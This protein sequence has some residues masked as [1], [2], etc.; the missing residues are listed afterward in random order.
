MKQKKRCLG[1]RLV[2]FSQWT[3]KP[4]ATFCSIGKV[5]KICV[6][7][8]TLTVVA[9]QAKCESLIDTA[10]VSSHIDIDEVIVA[11]DRTPVTFTQM[12]LQPTVI[13]T[14]Q[15]D[16]APQQSL[17]DFLEYIPSL[18]IRQRGTNDVQADLSIRGGSTDQNAIIINKI[19]FSDPQTG[20]N[21]FALPI[22]LGNTQKIEIVSGAQSRILGTNAL[23]GA[24]CF[25]TPTDTVNSA[26][27]RLT[28]GDYGLYKISV[29]T[30]LTFNRLSNFAAVA[31]SHSD[32]YT[33]N[34]DFDI[35]TVYYRG[36]Y[37]AK[38][39]SLNAQFGLTDKKFGSNG[40][41]TLSYPTQYEENM[42]TIGSI[43]IETG[44]RVKVAA[45][46][47]GR[48]LRDYYVLVRDNPNI[49]QNH[50]LTDVLGANLALETSSRIGRT[51][52]NA[53]YRNERISSNR[54]GNID[55]SRSRRARTSD[56]IRYDHF[57][58]RGYLTVALN[59]KYTANK[60]S[61]SVGAAILQHKSTEIYPG[62][63]LSYAVGNNLRLYAAANRSFRLP[64]FTDL[65]YNDPKHKQNPDLKAEKATT[66][67]FGLRAKKSIFEM[68][69][70]I[71]F[72]HGKNIIDWARTSS[73]ELYEAQ[74]I[75]ELN[76]FGQEV[77][78]IARP[79]EIAKSKWLTVNS[80]E[81]GYSHIDVSKTASG[82]ESLYAMDQLKHKFTAAINLQSADRLKVDIRV[83]YQKRNG[84]Y[85]S[86]NADGTVET[87]PY[88]GFWTFDA[89]ASYKIKWLSVFAE[90][91]NIGNSKCF[92]FSG[93]QLPERWVKGGVKISIE[94]LR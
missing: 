22:D 62:I 5:I 19:N 72:R 46:V 40:F 30:N 65:F 68:S 59:N 20:H 93:L 41:Y 45:N 56:T 57:Y 79:A 44:Q 18:D 43:G 26:I 37:K 27:A 11:T 86:A 29:A 87:H 31:K 63:D 52:L 9:T 61:M 36:V 38:N 25:S 39:I 4:Y 7:V 33:E 13:S 34:T 92:D 75:T 69:G 89:G 17:T 84:N 74:N 8:D 83:V 55:A 73:I 77:Q 78:I 81:C 32:G 90:A 58:E 85:D 82:Y 23:N 14:R 60:F 71:Y 6:L 76:T 51:T 16:A 10:Q 49:Y 70:N 53:E 2:H 3:R 66:Y 47:Y 24:V 21:N 91:T 48:H 1:Q 42:L 15:L 88:N 28:V 67:E 12:V 35:Q 64:T 80:V 94:E 50:H 54:L